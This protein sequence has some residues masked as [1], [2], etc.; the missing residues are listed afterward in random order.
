MEGTTC[1][2][3]RQVRGA[4]EK[5]APPFQRRQAVVRT[6]VLLA[7][8]FFPLKSCQSALGP[9]LLHSPL[10]H[11]SFRST[12]TLLRSDRL[13]AGHR[14]R[15]KEMADESSSPTLQSTGNGFDKNVPTTSPAQMYTVNDEPTWLAEA[16]PTERMRLKYEVCGP[17]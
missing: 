1:L 16:T 15:H 2:G 8:L 3:R 9:G 10:P 5:Y 6:C 13:A 12:F 7:E 11:L 14:A 4:L 17:S